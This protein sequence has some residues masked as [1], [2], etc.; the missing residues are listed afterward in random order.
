MMALF[1]LC[2]SV[3]DLPAVSKPN[4][5]K[6]VSGACGII[7]V[8]LTVRVGLSDLTS[9]CA[10]AATGYPNSTSNQTINIPCLL[11]ST[12]LLPTVVLLVRPAL[13]CVFFSCIAHEKL[14][15]SA[16]RLHDPVENMKSVEISI[17][18]KTPTL[19]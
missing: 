1:R 11:F 5:T 6:A 2:A 7:P 19:A 13:G 18:C 14:L 3:S 9:S 12:T 8:S 4:V 15:H 16:Y 10:H 17:H